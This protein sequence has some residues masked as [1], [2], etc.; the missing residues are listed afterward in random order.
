MTL[1]STVPHRAGLLRI[2]ALL[3]AA[4]LLLPWADGAQ[5]QA[6]GPSVAITDV[7][8]EAFPSVSANLTV[9]GANGLPLVGLTASNFTVLEDGTAVPA[10]DVALQSDASQPLTLVLAVDLAMPGEE[11]LVVQAALREF[12]DGLGAQDQVALLTFADEV[13]EAQTFTN[14]KVALA[15]AIGGL[16]PSGD[17]T[18]FNQAADTAVNLLGGLPAGRKAVLLFTDSGDT[19]DTLSPEVTI[20]SAQ[21]GEVALYP[22]GYGPKVNETIINNWARFTGGQA[23]LLASAGEIQSNLQ[24]LGVLLRQSY[25]I[26]YTSGVTADNARHEL[27]IELDY[28][29]QTATA[30]DRFVAVP[31]E[32]SIEGLTIANGQTL[33]GMVFLIAEVAAPAPVES[34]TFRLDGETLVELTSPPYRFDWDT[35]TAGA[36]THAVTIV[37]RDSA[38]NVGETQVSVN[39]AVPA[40]VA[41]TA[42]PVPT[43]AP[44]VSPVVGLAR[45]ALSIGQAVLGGALLLAGF[46]VAL[47]LWLRARE[48]QQPEPVRNCQ[49][50][51]TNRGNARTQY[52]L[53]AE[54]PAKLMKFQ[55]L[56]N[57]TSLAARVA[58]PAMVVPGGVAT[59]APA[60]AQLQAAAAPN[61]QANGK[62]KDKTK[63]GPGQANQFRKAQSGLFAIS[64]ISQ[65]I[66]GWAVAVTYLLPGR[67]SSR[68]RAQTAQVRDIGFQAQEAGQAPDRYGRIVEGVVDVDG[69]KGK[70]GGAKGKK[71]QAQNAAPQA[72]AAVA[73]PGG[74]PVTVATGP[75]AVGTLP[76][77]T[78]VVAAPGTPAFV[79]MT[80]TAGGWAVTPYLEPGAS[81]KIRLE[82][83]PLR[84][85]K[86]QTY[87]FR[88]L[89]RAAES[90]DKHKLTQIEHGSVALATVPWYK[91]A[92]PWLLFVV[93]LG[94]L[95]FFVW[96]VLGAFGVIGVG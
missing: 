94:A 50:E 9:T 54:D 4:A 24:T 56:V 69:I 21:A 38:G 13:V 35:A 26:V 90:K 88:V 39:V 15:T 45:S 95:A 55:F 77:A 74:A 30:S 51:L 29:D 82:I 18:V 92:L 40:P 34:V 73:V 89:S 27:T 53:R 70:F 61:G 62:G 79:N 67:V 16:T 6:T 17:T 28:Q 80:A 36:G 52:E 33:R 32:V 78:T 11:L 84:V 23:Y 91:Q 57:D 8:S 22:F 46:I 44:T 58:A 48:L 63:K 66:T 71:A 5:A 37:A 3:C 49:L 85:P 83:V 10:G 59:A 12:T 2:L 87:G 60:T 43:A 1:R 14:D 76:A 42:A 86:T 25:R 96:Y 47:L 75:A 81:L 7:D 72:G 64:S 41:P 19:A 65:R 93:M 31:G 20:N 68:I